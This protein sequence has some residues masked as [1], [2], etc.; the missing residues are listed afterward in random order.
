MAARTRAAADD[1]LTTEDHRNLGEYAAKL[2]EA[3]ALIREEIAAIIQGRLGVVNEFYAQKAELLKWLELRA[4]TVE[5][6][7]TKPVAQE[8]GLPGKLATFK[9]VLQEDGDLLK[10]MANVAASISREIE[11]V[12]NRDSLDGIYGKSGEKLS[13]SGKADMRLDHEI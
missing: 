7:L 13:K 8:H 1:G 12:M 9:T 5:P 2:D 3:T 11:K 4:P 6:F 10:R